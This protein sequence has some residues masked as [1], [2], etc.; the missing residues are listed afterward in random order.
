MLSA[1]DRL[2]AC[3]QALTHTALQAFCLAS[4]VTC[5]HW[6]PAGPAAQPGRTALVGG[7]HC[8]WSAWP[9]PLPAELRHIT[10]PASGS[11]A[12]CHDRPRCALPARPSSSDQALSRIII[13]IILIILA[14]QHLGKAA[15]QQHWHQHWHQQAMKHSPS[16]FGPARLRVARRQQSPGV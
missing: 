15:K 13:I 3:P 4:W 9:C 8:T 10:A 11:P 2:S 12:G 14:K 1:V 16:T 7:L 6:C 5:H